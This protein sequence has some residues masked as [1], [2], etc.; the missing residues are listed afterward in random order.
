MAPSHLWQQP[1]AYGWQHTDLFLPLRVSVARNSPSTHVGLGKG[2]KS[3][4]TCCTRLFLGP[5]PMTLFSWLT[6][7]SLLVPAW[8]FQTPLARLFSILMV[9][10]T[11]SFTTGRR[12]RTVL[13]TGQPL[14]KPYSSLTTK[15]IVAAFQLPWWHMSSHCM[16]YSICGSGK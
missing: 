7:S 13:R 3:W 15:V 8:Q 11:C 6:L 5:T 9:A 4:P 10:H 1:E 2:L 12:M 14:S 16:T